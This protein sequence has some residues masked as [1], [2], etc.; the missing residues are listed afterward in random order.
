M[1]NKV[2]CSNCKQFKIRIAMKVKN[3][4]IF[5]SPGN[6]KW[7]GSTTCP[8]CNFKVKRIDPESFEE[9]PIYHDTKNCAKCKG[10]LEL[11]RY[12]ICIDCKPE[13]G[14]DFSINDLGFSESVGFKIS[15][16]SLL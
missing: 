13:L 10:K 14:E 6:K 9:I 12:K 15:E 4:L 8:D 3:R 2:K 5:M 11:S 16:M 7:R 1:K